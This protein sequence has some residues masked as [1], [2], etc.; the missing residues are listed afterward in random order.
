LS[1]GELRLFVVNDPD[2]CALPVVVKLQC[3]AG[4]SHTQAVSGSLPN[5]LHSQWVES[6]VM[7][8]GR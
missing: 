2:A 1:P 7:G 4:R 8:A 5:Y 6:C 3:G